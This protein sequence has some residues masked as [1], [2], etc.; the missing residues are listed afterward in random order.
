MDKEPIIRG[1]ELPPQE[2][3]LERQE[4]RDFAPERDGKFLTA[5]E[6]FDDYFAHIDG[7]EG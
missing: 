7:K 4:E 1:F 5:E 3:R 2:E 6:Y